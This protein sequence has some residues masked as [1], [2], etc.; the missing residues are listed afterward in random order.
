MTNNTEH[1]LLLA[2][3]KDRLPFGQPILLLSIDLH[4]H[5]DLVSQ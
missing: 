3:K 5:F 4:Y 1:A 2:L